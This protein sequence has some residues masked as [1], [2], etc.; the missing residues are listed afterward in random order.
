MTRD[1]VRPAPAGGANQGKTGGAAAWRGPFA[2]MTRDQVRRARENGR[3]AGDARGPGGRRNRDMPGT[4]NL[5]TDAAISCGIST[6]MGQ[7]AGPPGQP[8]R[9]GTREPGAKAGSA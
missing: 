3:R 4:A 9:N 1:Q 7:A 8:G 2:R 6:I 5:I